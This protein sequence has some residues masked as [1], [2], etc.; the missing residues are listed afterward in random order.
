M[1][2]DLRPLA[3]PAYLLGVVLLLVAAGWA[4]VNRRF[5]PVPQVGGALGVAALAAGVL[6]DPERVRRALTGRQARYGSNALVISLA[7]LGILVV[8]NYLAY[9]N[10][11]RADLTEDRQYTLAPETLLTLSRLEQPVVIKGFYPAEMQSTQED[12]RPLLEEFRIHSEGK[13]RY[14]F[15]D[16]WENPVEARDYGVTRDGSLVVVYGDASQVVPY[17]TEEEITRALVRLINPEE[18]KIYFLTGHGERDLDGT[19]DEGYSEARAMLEGK[20][21]LI[22]SLNLRVDP[23]IP[24]DALA[25]VIAGPTTPLSEEEVQVLSDYLQNRGALVLLQQPR[26]E[27]RFGQAVDPLETYLASS[28]GVTVR[29][30]L[31]IEPRSSN[32]VVAISFDYGQHAISNGL[33]NLDSIFP[34]A[35][36]LDVAPV[37]GQSVYQTVLAYTSSYA[38]GETD[39]SFLE[40]QALPDYNEG[41]DVAGPLAL[42]VAAED[43]VSGARLVVVGDADFASNRWLAQYGNSSLWA[44]L[45]DW[46]SKEESLINLTPRPTT[47]RYVV[48][49]S[50]QTTGLIMLT[51]VVLMPGSVVV[52]GVYVWWQRRRRV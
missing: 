1:K 12:I 33:T 6:F 39:L 13:L 47:Q 22:D 27:T 52:L 18:R 45:V 34:V 8:L 37:E 46:A 25:V 50:V 51:T 41:V 11:A 5:D 20:N 49:P 15:I 32:F 4:A 19:G 38:W 30:D 26:A 44:N 31:V 3:I 10:P 35:R 42:A 17:T 24:D 48:P 29:D 43:P 7:F 21:Y 36:S 28:W 23:T 40:K 2:R 9:A 16:P 14:E